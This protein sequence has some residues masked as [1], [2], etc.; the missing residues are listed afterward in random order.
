MRIGKLPIV[1]AWWLGV[2]MAS[3]LGSGCLQSTPHIA[4]SQGGTLVRH[5]DGT[6][7]LHQGSNAK[8][9][10]RLDE[11]REDGTRLKAEL[12][13]SRDP[14]VTVPPAP[15]WTPMVVVIAGLITLIG[16]GVLAYK[17]WPRIGTRAALIG[18]GLIIIGLTVGSYAW[19]YALCLVVGGGY[20]LLE[21]YS[22][23]KKGEKEG[24]EYD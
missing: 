4:S 14:V 20:V 13:T 2:I 3:L 19:A 18:V 16:G 11:T 9:V 6:L 12:G 10:T 8:T 24:E 1:F 5:I 7:E 22:S 17:G 15:D 21:M 23:Y